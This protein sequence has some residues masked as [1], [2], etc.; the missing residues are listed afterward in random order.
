VFSALAGAVALHG[1]ARRRYGQ[2]RI[3]AF[4]A[5]GAVVAGWGVAQFP[6]LLVDSATID[7][8]AGAPVT[9]RLLLVVTAAAVLVVGPALA[10]LFR[11]A[12]QPEWK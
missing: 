9:L 8:A 11:L 6:D 4:T 12:D 3:G 7:E 5:V 10:W 2:A 1:L